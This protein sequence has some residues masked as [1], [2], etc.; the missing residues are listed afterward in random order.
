LTHTQI[1]ALAEP[2]KNHGMYYMSNKC[3]LIMVD[4]PLCPQKTCPKSMNKCVCVSFW[5]G[6]FESFGWEI[7]IIPFFV[8]SQLVTN[9]FEKHWKTIAGIWL[10][11]DW[12]VLASAEKQITTGTPSL[13]T[14]L[15]IAVKPHRVGAEALRTWNRSATG[16]GE[17]AGGF[18]CSCF[19]MFQ[20]IGL[21]ENSQETMVFTLKYRAFL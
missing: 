16:R 13:E 17:W 18:V 10:Q 6:G 12:H 3:R 19:T 20:W 21:R 5:L 8:W 1:Q 4:F 15:K 11:N 9:S 7:P 2:T 14:S